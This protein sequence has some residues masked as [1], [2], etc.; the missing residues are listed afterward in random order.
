MKIKNKLRALRTAITGGGA[1]KLQRVL[2]EERIGKA[3]KRA[4]KLQKKQLK[5]QAKAKAKAEKAGKKLAEAL[6][7]ANAL[8]A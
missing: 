2:Q 7:N 6:A 1:D 8:G 5:T 3:A 4:A